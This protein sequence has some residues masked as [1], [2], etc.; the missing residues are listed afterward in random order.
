MKLKI[1]ESIT[2]LAE[3]TQFPV[4][5]TGGF[6]R[7]AIVG[8]SGGD[9]D[10]CGPVAA[11][12]LGLPPRYMIRT[13]NFRLGTA[14]IKCGRA[15]FEYTPFRTE[16]YAKGGGHSPSSVAFTTDIKADVLR[17]D[18]C[19]NSLY[20]DVKKDELI[21]L[22]GGVADCENKLL[23][24]VNPHKTFASDGLRLMR[25]ARIAAETGF[26]IE[27]KTASA[28]LT[29][30]AN[31]KDISFE[32]KRVELDKILAADLKY[33]VTNAHYRGLKLLQKLGLLRYIIPALD[34]CEGVE[35][36]PQ[37]HKYD[38]LEHTFQTVRFAPPKVRLAALFHDTGKSYC[39]KVFGKMHGHEIASARM[40]AEAL[41]P[42]GL[43]Y[44]AAV[45]GRVV[46]LCRNHM[47]DI[48]GNTS[49]GKMRVFIA[50]EFDI[51]DDLIALIKADRAGSGV[52]EPPEQL[53]LERV[54]DE[55]LTDGTPIYVTELHIDGDDL[56]ELGYSGAAVG[57][58]LDDMH[59][60]CI[61]DPHLNNREWLL[62]YA[63]KHK[64]TGNKKSAIK[65]SSP[66]A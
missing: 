2:E 53:R 46:R 37:Y 50:K 49:E 4:Y 25:L 20:Y 59:H 9:V 27:A 28:A 5:V 39:A 45:L 12:A 34:S 19:C 42:Y 26:K 35:Q 38:V 18:F 11:A 40:A 29:S 21:D 32:R 15:E 65:I 64:P 61:I 60:K 36:N 51:I 10:L 3:N 7:D 14:I 63:L 57:E 22:V 17:R 33:G 56:T 6:V 31:L 52:G 43:K 8:F 48:N 62:S 54:K 44:S 30:A 13:V 23:R 41:G 24:S 58:I 16:N 1:P 66:S 47:Y 55:M